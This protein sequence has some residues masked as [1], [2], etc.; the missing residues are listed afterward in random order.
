[1]CDVQCVY[2]VRR[3]ITRCVTRRDISTRDPDPLH[4]HYTTGSLVRTAAQRRPGLGSGIMPSNIFHP[5]HLR[6]KIIFKSTKATR[7]SVQ[8]VDH[9]LRR[10]CA[11][12]RQDWRR[13]GEAGDDL[14][15]WDKLFIGL[16]WQVIITKWTD[17]DAGK[18]GAREN[19]IRIQNVFSIWLRNISLFLYVYIMLRRL[20]H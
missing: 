14:S 3:D 6:L 19:W 11:D 4:A 8:C 9:S 13:G 17:K 15:C 16:V 20:K 7:V 2:C 18:M 10:C 12:T 1:M 5:P